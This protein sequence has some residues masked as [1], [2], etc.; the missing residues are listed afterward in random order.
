[1]ATELDLRRHKDRTRRVFNNSIIFECLIE[2]VEEE[3][4]IACSAYLRNVVR[5][6]QCLLADIE[7]GSF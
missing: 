3:E 5:Y 1:M 6:L 4:V 2:Q 7:L